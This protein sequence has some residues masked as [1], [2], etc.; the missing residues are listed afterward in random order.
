MADDLVGKWFMIFNH[1]DE[2]TQHGCVKVNL[3]NGFY[4][5]EIKPSAGAVMVVVN[6]ADMK[7]TNVTNPP[8]DENKMMWQFFSSRKELCDWLEI[9]EH[10]LD[11]EEPDE[12]PSKHGLN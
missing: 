6:V 2:D 11:G 4:L 10:E 5:I 12:K 8:K 9:E 3:G 7:I 1:R